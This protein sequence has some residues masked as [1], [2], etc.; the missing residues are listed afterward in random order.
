MKFASEKARE[1]AMAVQQMMVVMKQVD[2]TCA[3]LLENVSVRELHLISHVGDHGSVMMT[4]IAEF[5]DI[6]MSTATSVVDKMV[7]HRILKRGESPSDRRKVLIQLD[8]DGQAAFDLFLKMRI[9]MSDRML[10]M[11]EVD[12][13]E[14]FI[15]IVQKIIEGLK[16]TSLS[17]V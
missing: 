14:E 13:V 17:K 12:E 15:R 9:E 11:L 8:E 3:H 1:L 4:A 5:L 16:S 7:E 6:P 10:A 2:E